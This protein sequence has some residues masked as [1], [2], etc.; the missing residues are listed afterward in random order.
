V[1][2]RPREPHVRCA[3]ERSPTPLRPCPRPRRRGMLSSAPLVAFLATTDL[4]RSH[5]FYGDVLGLRRVEPSPFANVYDANGTTLRVTRVER[6]AVAPYTVLGW[7]VG[8]VHAAID[9]LT[10]RGTTFEHIDGVDQDDSGVWT[11]PGGAR[12]AWFNDPDGNLLS[13]TELPASVSAG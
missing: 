8:D 5:G 10:R 11:A 3:H 2:D 9:D 6:L 1:F 7:T 13:L 4:D 12:I